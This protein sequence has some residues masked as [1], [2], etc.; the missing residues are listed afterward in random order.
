M[1]DLVVIGGGTAGLVAARTAV[2]F[3][4]RVLLVERDRLGGDCLWT[5]CVPSKSLIAAANAAVTAW[6]S[7]GLGIDT[8]HA[9]VDFDAV[10]RHVRAAMATIAPTDSAESLKRDGIAVLGAEAEFIDG[11]TL[12]AGDQRIRFRQAVI[13]TG[14]HPRVL[15]APGADTVAMLTSENV[16]GLD[17][18]PQRLLVIGGGAIGCELG[19]A[20]ARLGSR[21]TLIQRG[22]RL[23]PKESAE[24]EAIISAALAADGVEVRTGHT[25]QR[26]V[27]P[28]A[29]AGVAHLDDG[30]TV[31]FDR[32]LVALGR[33]PNSGGLGLEK[34]KVRT[35]DLGR[36][37]VDDHLR[38]N[39]SRIWAA[40]D[41]TPLPQFTHTAGIN[42]SIAASNAIL[43]LKRKVDRL[44]V[45]RVTFTQPEV[46]A[47]GLQAARSVTS[48][49]RVITIDHQH[50][51]RA[52][53]EATTAGFTQ[54]ITDRAG[55]L[56]GAT[57]V[58]PRAGESLAEV[59]M[60]VKNRLTAGQI[61][62]TTHPYPTFNDAVWN[63]CVSIVRDRL[64]G[65]LLKRAIRGL[66]TIRR[67]LLR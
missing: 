38:T 40:G 21:V 12:L 4:A 34:A 58:G 33:I 17:A 52:V 63:A 48:R 3:G 44:A 13:A 35:D 20:M 2:S 53:A 32:V 49:H 24:A 11:R 57:I 16:W 5:G 1:W 47:V 7:T 23:L 37:L 15:A 66:F 41:I 30:T 22:G 50:V 19:Q 14:G 43:G 29:V 61:A 46:A 55:T 65:G 6:H 27:S 25:V 8:Q 39:N 60:A 31:E 62:A 51:D 28:D 26:I 59:T 42:G 56:L 67:M 18:L 36:V 45:P 9:A 64:S 10:M 54:I